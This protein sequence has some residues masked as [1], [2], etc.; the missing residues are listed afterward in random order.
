MSRKQGRILAAALVTGLATGAVS[1]EALYI[2]AGLGRVKTDTGVSNISGSAELDEKDSGFKLFAGYQLNNNVAIE[3]Q[4][5]DLGVAELTGNTGDRF[6][7]EGVLLQFTED[8]AR[9]AGESKSAGIAM[10]VGLDA[11]AT[12]NPYVKF[13]LQ[14]W[15]VDY[16]VSTPT[17]TASETE[18]GS[19]PF[20]GLGVGFRVTPSL[21][22]MAEYERYDI[23]DSDSD[24]ISFSLSWRFSE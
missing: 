10:L 15:S 22:A 19:D 11:T 12:I 2:G 8:N 23:D 24:F 14:K 4:Y 9:I 7:L 16:T 13:G 3:I 20:F 1:A 5:A 18:K 6:E 17:L 21:S